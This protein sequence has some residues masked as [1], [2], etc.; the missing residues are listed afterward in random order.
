[1][2]VLV[3]G[4]SGWIGSAAVREL[5]QA[6][7]QVLGLARSDAAA[8]VVAGL[9]AEV[10]R[11]GLDDL[12]SLRAGAAASDGVVHLAYHHDFTQM[13]QAARLDLTAIEAIG[14]VLEG[15]GHPLVIASGVAGLTPG[16]VATE[17]DDADPAA[18]PRIANAA[19][20]LALAD[21]GVRPVVVRFAPTVHAEGDH[22]FVARLVEIARAK[23]V[24]AYVGDGA[25]RWPAVH[26]AD[27]GVLVR[28]AVEQAPAG[29]VLH[30]VAEEGVSTRAIAEAVGRGLDLPVVSVSTDDA[31]EHFGWLGRFFALDCPASSELTRTQVGWEPTRPGLLE[32]LAHGYY[33]RT[34]TAA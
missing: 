7:H 26:R 28:L 12:E 10:H 27:A 17:R 8:A 15:T 2:R 32:D 13:A 24:S 22:G 4:A 6:G 30:A 23:G 21:R 16:H 19:A 25:N 29:S 18:H 3:T 11:G 1:M 31:A 34:P 5:R 14:D 33:F 9:G 20:A